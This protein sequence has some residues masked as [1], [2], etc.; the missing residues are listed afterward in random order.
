MNVSGAWR[1]H[2]HEN[3]WVPQRVVSEHKHRMRDGHNCQVVGTSFVRHVYSELGFRLLPIAERLYPVQMC[4]CGCKCAWTRDVFAFPHFYTY[5]Y[6]LHKI[7]CLD[8]H[9]ELGEVWCLG[10]A[11]VSTSDSARHLLQRIVYLLPVSWYI[12]VGFQLCHSGGTLEIPDNPF[13]GFLLASSLD[14]F[15]N[16]GLR[17]HIWLSFP[18]PV[19][20]MGWQVEILKFISHFILHNSITYEALLILYFSYHA[21]EVLG[22]SVPALLPSYCEHV[23]F[24]WILF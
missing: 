18:P 20:P 21:A 8:L 1:H 13:R 15:H 14:S 3:G 6:V 22:T 12:T 5:G 10:W 11:S 2:S 9:H 7:A 19:I 17:P 4:G 16:C 24:T 23:F